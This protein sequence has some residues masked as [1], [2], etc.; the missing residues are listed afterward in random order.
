MNIRGLLRATLPLKRSTQAPRT[1]YLHIGSHKTGTT[2]LQNTLHSNSE[3]LARNGYSYY[4]P[5]GWKCIHPFM[6]RNKAKGLVPNGMH[7]H[8]LRTLL[9][10]MSALQGDI[11]AS[12]ENLSF[13]F[14]LAQLRK[15]HRVLVRG[16]TQIKI[17]CYI[18]RQDSHVVSHHQEGTKPRR[19]A[20]TDLFGFESRA[21][22]H[23]HKQHDLYLDYNAK[24]AMW[25]EVFG[26]ENI[27]VRVFD[28][29]YLKDGDAV[30]DFLD[31]VGI[32][33]QITS[34][35]R[36]NESVGYEKSKLGHLINQF[37]V[38]EHLKAA[39]LRH[40]D[41]S[42]KLLPTPEEA[43]AY[44]ARYRDSNIALNRQFS[45]SEIDSIF[46]EDDFQKGTSNQSM[47]WTEESANRAMEH[48]IDS[49]NHLFCDLSVDELRDIAINIESKN[50][51]LSHQL[52][53][54]A[55][56]LLPQGEYIQKKLNDYKEKLQNRANP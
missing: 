34:Q 6:L 46:P 48:L 44:Y 43:R 35:K 31:I 25:S 1:L 49:V 4:A 20:E 10:E 12:S 36:L 11:I 19:H 52:M 42:G 50:L 16:F 14:E 28:H 54:V 2:S 38:D 18:R 8:H 33:G 30:K 45:L 22:P 51:E 21:I 27:I 5:A 37:A 24:L 26:R 7:F 56:K 41:N 39:L 13:V 9:S 32:E 55:A 17:V 53:A 40:C 15:L 29:R 47:D 23:W 3:T